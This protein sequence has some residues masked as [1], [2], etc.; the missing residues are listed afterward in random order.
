MELLV[1]AGHVESHL[2]LFRDSVS[3]GAQ[4]SQKCTNGSKMVL[5]TPDGTPR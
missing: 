5:D 4:F 2:F 1:D 3:V